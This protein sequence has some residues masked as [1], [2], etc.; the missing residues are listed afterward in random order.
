[1][2]T[3]AERRNKNDNE[4]IEYQVFGRFKSHD[5]A[6]VADAGDDDHKCLPL[7][8][9]QL[10]L[11]SLDFFCTTLPFPAHVASD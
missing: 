1:M 3:R 7:K 5:F 11:F 2:T 10:T 4:T 6:A 8:P 9:P